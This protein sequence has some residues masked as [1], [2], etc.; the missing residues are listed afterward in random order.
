MCEH[1]ISSDDR[2]LGTEI[3]ARSVELVV[4]VIFSMLEFAFYHPWIG[5]VVWAVP[6]IV[7]SVFRGLLISERLNDSLEYFYIV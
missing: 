2:K 6:R 7:F 5:G 3:G 4:I 1:L